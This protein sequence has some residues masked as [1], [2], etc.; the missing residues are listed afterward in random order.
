MDVVSEIE[1]VVI[2]ANLQT[3]ILSSMVLHPNSM[4]IKVLGLELV[5]V[6]IKVAMLV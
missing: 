5:L 3:K 1:V 4:A 2:L 6:D